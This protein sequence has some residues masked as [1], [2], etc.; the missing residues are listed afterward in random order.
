MSIYVGKLLYLK[1]HPNFCVFVLIS[2]THYCNSSR[3]YKYR[4]SGSFLPGHSNSGPISQYQSPNSLI[5]AKPRRLCS[6]V[7]DPTQC[8]C[9]HRKT[10]S[11][12][13][14]THPRNTILHLST[15][16]VRYFNQQVVDTSFPTGGGRSPMVE[17]STCCSEGSSCYPNRTRHPV[18]HRCIEHRMWKRM[19]LTVLVAS[20]N[21]TVVSY[22]NKQAGTR[23]IQLCRRT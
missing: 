11:S 23:S 22:I 15:L 12:G 3:G 13:T 6:Y 8:L 1:P 2:A 17:I 7:A 14:A 16:G 18:V 10:G 5:P 19:G 21:S 20:D 4:I 9:V